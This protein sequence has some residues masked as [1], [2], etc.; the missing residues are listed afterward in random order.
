MESQA[1]LIAIATI[2]LTL[3][4]AST[5]QFVSTTISHLTRRLPEI[6]H[7]AKKTIRSRLLTCSEMVNSWRFRG[8]GQLAVDAFG[9]GETLAGIETG[10][11]PKGG[12]NREEA[13]ALAAPA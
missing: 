3:I 5:A 7:P 11:T 2:D 6:G 8:F 10:A 4:R 13:W 1:T 12:A 9:T